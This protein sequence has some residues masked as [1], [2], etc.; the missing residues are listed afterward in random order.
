MSH[1]TWEVL[2]PT[3]PQAGRQ[4]AYLL[5]ARLPRGRVAAAHDVG[6]DN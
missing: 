6:G 5:T 1:G 3:V 4:Q 2:E